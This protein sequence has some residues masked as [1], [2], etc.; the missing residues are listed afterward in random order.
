ME[1][2]DSARLCIELIKFPLV[3]SGQL[4]KMYPFRVCFHK[5]LPFVGVRACFFMLP[6]KEIPDLPEV[7]GRKPG[8]DIQESPDYVQSQ[9]VRGD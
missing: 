4:I 6:T 9:P 1:T 2:C 3:S 7:R 5:V 8:A